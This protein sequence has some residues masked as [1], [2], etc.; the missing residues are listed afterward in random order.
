MSI[1]FRRSKAIESQIDE[2]LDATSEGGMNF[3]RGIEAFLK[4]DEK[5]FL[6]RLEALRNLDHQAIELRRRIENDLY[7][8]SLMPQHRGDVVELLDQVYH[9]L[10]GAKKTLKQ[11]DVE[12][13]DIPE[14]LVEDFTELA[15]TS[16]EAT[17]EL[18]RAVRVF[19]RDIHHVK[20]HLHK[21]RF[22]EKEADRISDGI[23]RKVFESD[24]E[25][26]RKFHLRYFALHIETLSDHAETVAD[27]VAIAAIKQTL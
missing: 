6:A 13:P 14:Y 4:G 21:V 15:T 27:L 3:Q 11:F 5:P 16:V 17:E 10:N 9:L 1:L 8:H 25:L 7:S 18:I 12:R 22:L 20:N 19:F 23:K 24:L 26:A 2:L